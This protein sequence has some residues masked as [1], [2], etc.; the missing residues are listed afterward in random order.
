MLLS[1]AALARIG[2]F[3]AIKDVLAED[4]LTG[5][6]MTEAGYRVALSAHV[7]PAVSAHQSV[8]GFARRHLRW[9]QMRRRISVS[10]Y[11][12]E[13]LFNPIPLAAAA[14]VS[15]AVTEGV[16]GPVI[17]VAGALATIKC[18]SEAALVARLRG[19]GVRLRY[20][21]AIPLKDA[22]V[23]AIWAVGAVRRKVAWRGTVLQIG[24]E[25]R[26]TPLRP[27]VLPYPDT[28]KEAA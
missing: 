22:L 23:A 19:H 4:Y 6:L 16:A 3:A 27:A 14:V 21:A 18:A 26:L 8:A 13:L 24:P 11:A 5:K 25:S 9:A 15:A 1:R 2:G 12:G 10:A 20:L 17:G 7:L 28:V